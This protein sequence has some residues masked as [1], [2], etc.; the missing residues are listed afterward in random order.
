MIFPFHIADTPFVATCIIIQEFRNVNSDVV[1]AE[2]GFIPPEMTT[3]I[4]F[5]VTYGNTTLKSRIEGR[6]E[7]NEMYEQARSTGRR[8][9]MASTDDNLDSRAIRSSI[10]NISG[11]EIVLV[12]VEYILRVSYEIGRRDRLLYLLPIWNGTYSDSRTKFS[13]PRPNRL[14]VRV[15]LQ[16]AR[17]IEMITYN[18]AKI[19][20]N[21]SIH[22][23]GNTLENVSIFITIIYCITCIT[24]ANMDT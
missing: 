6:E 4:C 1:D 24:C 16:R 2:F 11:R 19:N 8:A 23:D 5:E 7:A 18:I 22:F 12:K 9:V 20:G 17:K 21:S 13:V 15:D 10:A 14:I 3:L